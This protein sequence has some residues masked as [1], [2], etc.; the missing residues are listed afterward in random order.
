M[1]SSS[2]GST[3]QPK[4]L[5]GNRRRQCGV[6][7]AD[8]F[9]VQND[10]LSINSCAQ[11]LICAVFDPPDKRAEAVEK[12][13][14]NIELLQE[15]DRIIVR[16][17]NKLLD[18]FQFIKLWM[19]AGNK[20]TNCTV[21]T[22]KQVPKLKL[23]VVTITLNEE[24]AI[25]KVIKDIQANAGECEI[26]VVDSSTDSTPE[27]AASLGARVIKQEPCGYGVAM[28]T[29]LLF[30][31]GDVIIT[32]DCDDTYPMEMIP[33]FMRLIEEGYDVVS[34]SRLLGHVKPENMPL[35]NWFGNWLFAT[36]TSVLYGFRTT[37]VTT[38]M[39]AYRRQVLHSIPWETNYALP[40][41]LIIRPYLASYKIK[42][43][44]IPY[45]E[46]VGEITLNKWRSGK[47]F[48]RGICKYKFGWQIDPKLL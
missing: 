45:R 33:E 11:G 30:G 41:E 44:A 14:S 5:S 4:A 25:G 10:P 29:A 37:D 12:S 7:K 13:R 31:S 34:G 28:K 9:P 42:E 8:Q 22:D 38:G 36:M 23:S 46:R 2:A 35:M 17:C 15:R 18:L 32:T 48:L 1:L 6:S 39:R 43:I 16:I 21:E 27:I 3:R 24:K 40:A 26:L 47:A 19:H 20:I